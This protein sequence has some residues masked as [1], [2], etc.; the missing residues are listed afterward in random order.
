[1]MTLTNESI[2][3]RPFGVW[4]QPVNSNGFMFS[5][6]VADLLSIMVAHPELDIERV[7]FR[8]KR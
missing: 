1:M 7:S 6:S 3:F 2:I 4:I 5:G 8:V